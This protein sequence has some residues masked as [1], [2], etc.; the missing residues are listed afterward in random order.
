MYSKILCPV[1]GSDTSN[2]GMF[3]AIRLAGEQRAEL[4]F[5]HVIDSGPIAMYLPLTATVFECI[6]ECGQEVLDSAIAAAHDRGVEAAGRLL[7]TVQDR[8]GFAIAN[9][10]ARFKPDLIVMGTQ[11]RHGIDRLLMGS[12]A[13]TVVGTTKAPVLLVKDRSAA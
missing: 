13:A 4:L 11:G 8:V 2:R 10:A 7:T 12:D 3:E 9:E 1:D 6:R 5:V